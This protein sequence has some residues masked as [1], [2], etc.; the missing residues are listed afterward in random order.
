MIERDLTTGEPNGVLIGMERMVDE[1]VPN[2]SYD[3]LSG[4]VREASRRFL[5]AG[6]VTIQDAT[7][8]NGA[9]AWALF[10]RLINDGSLP[11]DVV[12][13]EGA[14]HLGELPKSA[15]NDRLVR[16][17]VKV[18]IHEL[19]NSEPHDG[20]LSGLGDA[21]RSALGAGRQLAIHAV[22]Q[23]AVKAAVDAL[24]AGLADM[25]QPDHRH[26]IEHCSV[27]PQGLAERM[28]ALGIMVASEPSFVG[29]RGD[30]YRQLMSPDE[31]DR[32]YAF[33][34]LSEA[35]VRL[36]AGSDAPVVPP[37]PLAAVA[38]AAGRKAASGATIGPNEAVDVLAAL[39]WW[40]AG[41]ARAAFLEAERGCL[42]PGAFADIVLLPAGALELPLEEL[43]GC[44]PERVWRRGVDV[45]PDTGRS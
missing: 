43:A 45:T 3:E 16:G 40:T 15:L 6:I 18:M 31:L 20:E 34:S 35:G 41:S 27:L 44:L 17:P 8:T 28:A 10:E 2:L 9:S 33:R 1:A 25:P 14:E 7:H 23:G 36:A 26:R 37:N 13:M 19:E 22:G 11:L 4:A 24:E 39:R 29:A 32:L 30:R 5:R 12:M 42:K 21:V 38:A